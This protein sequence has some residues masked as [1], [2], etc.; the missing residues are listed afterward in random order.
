MVRGHSEPPMNKMII[1]NLV[2]RPIRSLISVG[3]IA[4]EVTLILVIVGLSMGILKDSAQRQAGI[5]ADVMVKPPGLSFI[6]SLSSAPVSIKVANVLAK[7]PHVVAV[8][9]VLTQFN[10]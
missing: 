2:H 8:A 1:S 3:A 10:T 6:G 7:M 4:V 5:G 9:P